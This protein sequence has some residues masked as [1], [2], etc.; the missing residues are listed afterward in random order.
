M[1][2]THITDLLH[3]FYNWTTYSGIIAFLGLVRVFV[4][5]IDFPSGRVCLVWRP[6]ERRCCGLIV[7]FRIGGGDVELIAMLG[8]FPPTRALQPCCGRPR[9]RVH[10]PI[11]AG[12]ARGAAAVAVLL[13]AA[14]IPAMFG[15][16]YWNP[17]T[18]AVNSAEHSFPSLFLASSAPWQW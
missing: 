5:G 18:E 3:E 4:L 15:L 10:G 13:P 6:A 14:G 7:L 12:V 17:L 8:A 1:A 16:A 2:D 11:G 9:G